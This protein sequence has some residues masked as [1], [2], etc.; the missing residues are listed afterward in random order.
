[1]EDKRE[2]LKLSRSTFPSNHREQ[3][4]EIILS[5]Y[6]PSL[7]TY[8]LTPRLIRGRDG[9]EVREQRCPN[10]LPRCGSSCLCARKCV[11]LTYKRIE[12][13]RVKSGYVKL[14]AKKKSDAYHNAC[15]SCLLRDRVGW[16]WGSTSPLLFSAPER[17]IKHSVIIVST[18]PP[19]YS[20]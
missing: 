6:D 17:R 20:F 15:S 9:K 3:S 2:M 18:A 14:K 19:N 5:C 12:A 1:M 10:N 8:R 4:E 16:P 11:K 13:V 7:T